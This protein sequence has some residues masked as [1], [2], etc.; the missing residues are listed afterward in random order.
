[1]K[2]MNLYF[3]NSLLIFTKFISKISS[4]DILNLM[5]YIKV[6]VSRQ[7]GWNLVILCHSIG[8][9]WNYTLP[10]Y[11]KKTCQVQV[12]CVCVECIRTCW[13]PRHAQAVSH[14]PLIIE[15]T[16]QSQA[17]PCVICGRQS[18]TGTGYSPRFCPIS[19]I[20][21]LFHSPSFIHSS[22]NDTT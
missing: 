20:P 2:L 16:F 10:L 12:K 18:G 3:L 15:A 22:N 1:M 13:Q 8:T 21:P 9:F 4:C 5:E 17:S 6:K 14:Q 19:I 7:R 11:V